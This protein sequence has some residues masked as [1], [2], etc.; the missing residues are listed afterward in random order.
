MGVF[1]PTSDNMGICISRYRQI[2]AGIRLQ[3][4]LA[5][6]D[7]RSKIAERNITVLTQRIKKARTRNEQLNMAK[8]ILVQ[9]SIIANNQNLQ[10]TVSTIRHSADNKQALDELKIIYSPVF[11]A[12]GD[13]YKYEAYL[14]YLQM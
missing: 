11:D 14:F 13:T 4:R 2:R 5:E 1:E 6:S 10:K 7:R 8:Q 9:R 12:T 3:E